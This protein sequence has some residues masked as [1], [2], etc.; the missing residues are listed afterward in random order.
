MAQPGLFTISATLSDQRGSGVSCADGSDGSISITATGGT[1]PYAHEWSGPNGFSATTQSISAVAPG[2]YTYTITDSNGCSAAE[3]FTLTAPPP[4]S[5]S[6][7][8]ATANGG[9]NIGC[10]GASTGSIDATNGGGLPPYAFSWNGPDSF[11]SSNED[12]GALVA[13]DYTLTVTDANGCLAV[14]AVTLTQAPGLIGIASAIS[15][16]SC[17]GASHR[18]SSP[19]RWSWR[20]R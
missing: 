12:I 19:G 1:G 14:A 20:F 7:M 17:S 9:W 2:A 13:G 3:S 15:P 16:V 18:S 10:N 11:T 4:M 5:L 6:A 8:A